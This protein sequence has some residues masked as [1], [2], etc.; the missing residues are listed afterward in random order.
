VVG[1][2]GDPEG[3]TRVI[4]CDAPAS[5]RL[6]DVWLCADH[7]DTVADGGVV[8]QGYFDQWLPMDPLVF[9]GR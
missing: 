1:A 5:I 7:Y 6:N 3:G 2:Q 8:W 9:G 4:V